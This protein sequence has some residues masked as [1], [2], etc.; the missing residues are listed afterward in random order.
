MNPSMLHPSGEVLADSEMNHRIAN[1]LALIAAIVELDGRTV[2]DPQAAIVLAATQRRIH[3][4]ASVHRALYREP[5]AETVNLGVFLDELGDSLRA[6]VSDGRDRR[7]IT[8]KADDFDLPNEHAA[9]FAIMVSELVGNACKHAYRV[10]DPGE[11]RILFD[12]TP[13]GDWRL[14]VEDDGVGIGHLNGGERGLGSHIIQAVC[15]KLGGQYA[16]EACYPGTRFMMWAGSKPRRA[17]SSNAMTMVG[18]ILDAEHAGTWSS[19]G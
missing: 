10:D 3:A 15:K 13:S 16:W 12:A 8:V 19:K 5:L 11:V 7:T 6:L 1:N 14:A 9:A 18:E 17:R 4:V 2:S